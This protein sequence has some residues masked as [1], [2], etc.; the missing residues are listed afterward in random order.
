MKR[1]LMCL[2]I[3]TL[4]FPSLAESKET[5]IVDE[6]GKITLISEGLRLLTK[7]EQKAF[8]NPGEEVST[9]R[10]K[11]SGE[12]VSFFWIEMTR[13]YDSVVVFNGD[14]LQTISKKSAVF[15]HTV[16]VVHVWCM[17]FAVILMALALMTVN[18][19]NT[20]LI[21]FAML[22][23][24][25]SGALN[26]VMLRDFANLFFVAMALLSIVPSNLIDRNRYAMVNRITFASFCLF[27]IVSLFV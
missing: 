19:D 21:L 18:Y 8:D 14:A 22:F 23:A 27:G 9:N 11:T 25:M 1:F 16:S 2:V 6:S 5:P 7:D 17:L 3:L 15:S 4:L 26:F 20:A 10:T 12:R 24:I 13:H